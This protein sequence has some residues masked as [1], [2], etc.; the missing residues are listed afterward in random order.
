V[1]IVGL[2]DGE[3]G[4]VHRVC[5]CFCGEAHGSPFEHLCLRLCEHERTPAG[6]VK[7]DTGKMG[8]RGCERECE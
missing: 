8:S 1:R 5:G 6:T 7:C 2:G 3:T 4:A